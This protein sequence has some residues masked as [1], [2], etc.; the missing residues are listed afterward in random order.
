MSFLFINFLLHQC[1]FSLYGWH[2]GC[3]G[4]QR[5]NVDSTNNVVGGRQTGKETQGVD[6]PWRWPGSWNVEGWAAVEPCCRLDHRRRGP[7]QRPIPCSGL[8]ERTQPAPEFKAEEDGRP[9][10]PRYQGC[11]RAP[12]GYIECKFFHTHGH[13]LCTS[14]APWAERMHLSRDDTHMSHPSSD[15]WTLQS[16]WRVFVFTWA[17]LNQPFGRAKIGADVGLQPAHSKPSF[18]FLAATVSLALSCILTN[19]SSQKMN[20][21]RSRSAF[22]HYSQVFFVT[23]A[24]KCTLGKG[25]SFPASSHCAQFAGFLSVPL[26]RQTASPW[27][28]GGCL[29]GAVRERTHPRQHWLT[30]AMLAMQT[31]AH[32]KSMADHRKF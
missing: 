28:P 26:P 13:K 4:L 18:M 12:H 24:I 7:I 29:V 1:L 20:R 6:C 5:G 11:K 17:A 2:G 14:V 31:L 19:Q 16:F 3:S 22:H 23:R 30:V 32:C 10:N 8:R 15:A 21:R 9:E 27:E 25:W